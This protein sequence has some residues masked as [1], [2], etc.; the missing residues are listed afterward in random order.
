MGYTGK[1]Y[2]L[3]P[4]AVERV[5][6]VQ[7]VIIA[8]QGLDLTRHIQD[9][10]ASEVRS[11]SVTVTSAQILDLDA[12]PI[13]LLPTLGSNQAYDITSVCSYINFNTTPYTVNS[14]KIAVAVNGYINYEDAICDAFVSNQDAFYK[15]GFSS[16][17]PIVSGIG[18]S[19]IL[20]LSDGTDLTDG[21]S[22]ITFFI[23]YRIL[24]L[25]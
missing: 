10:V 4:E 17:A 12:N 20:A 7:D 11:T 9:V 2:K 1:R 19:A 18:G 25:N 24:T 23:Q 16:N 5:N 22:P 13:E 8:R 15:W 3:K 6:T 14:T 21:D